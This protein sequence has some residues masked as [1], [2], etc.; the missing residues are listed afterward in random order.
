MTRHTAAADPEPSARK[1]RVRFA[2]MLIAVAA[3]VAGGVTVTG[4]SSA[5]A[6]EWIGGVHYTE[7]YPDS[8]AAWAAF[9]TG[10]PKKG[11]Y[12]IMLG[13]CLNM[14]GSYITKAG[15][16]SINTANNAVIWDYSCWA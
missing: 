15:T 13:Q 3:L 5:Q 11:N 9:Q 16:G 8:E 6:A 14:G 7:R 1:R 2:T 4:M 10:Q 12:Y